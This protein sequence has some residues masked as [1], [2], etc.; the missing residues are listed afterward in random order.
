MAAVLAGIATIPE[1]ADSLRR[2]LASIAP[3]VD[4]VALSLNDY[5]TRPAWLDEFPNVDATVKPSNGGDAEKFAA[6]DDWEIGRAHV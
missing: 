1:R 3:H 5:T 4:R 6:V 2:T